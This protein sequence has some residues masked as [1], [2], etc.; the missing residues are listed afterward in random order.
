MRTGTRRPAGSRRPRDPAILEIPADRTRRGSVG[1]W[2]VGLPGDSHVHSEWSWDAP[3]GSMERSC[4]EAVKLG[5]PAIAF[6]E[7]VDHTAFTVPVDGPFASEHLTSLAGADGTLAPPEFD[8]A[9][10]SR[11]SSGV[12]TGSRTSGS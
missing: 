1:R 4:A 2:G 12:A 5:L 3:L 10:T 9:V 8:P 11:R 6:T 7:H